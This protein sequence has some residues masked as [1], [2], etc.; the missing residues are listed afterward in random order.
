MPAPRSI[1]AAKYGASLKSEL[2]SNRVTSITRTQLSELLPNPMSVFCSKPIKQPVRLGERFRS[3]RE[4]RG[5]NVSSI[6]RLSHIPRKY[7]AA[8]EN[9]NFHELPDARAHRLAYVK[10]YA[11]TL[12]L[13]AEE[14]ASQFFHE[15]GLNGVSRKMKITQFAA[16]QRGQSISVIIR[17]IVVVSCVMLFIGYLAWQVK[18]I[19]EP[20]SL[21]IV[22]P[23][24]GSVVSDRAVLVQGEAEAGTKLAVN[25]QEV[26]ADSHGQFRIP[27]DLVEGLNTLTIAATKKHGKTTARLVNVILKPTTF[28]SN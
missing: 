13:D 26:A 6:E 20:P 9:G 10:H 15:N 7:L 22:T 11:S 5:W 25:G 2:Y 19:I 24:D 23:L 1:L 16:T 18:G 12:G 27:I 8:L 14:C 28:S 3:E 4:N 17:N 21:V